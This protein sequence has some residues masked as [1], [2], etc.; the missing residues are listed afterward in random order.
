MSQNIAFLALVDHR[1]RSLVV[2]APGS[3]LPAL[4][5]CCHVAIN[6]LCAKHKLQKQHEYCSSTLATRIQRSAIHQNQ[7]PLRPK[8]RDCIQGG[9]DLV[10]CN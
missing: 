5:S 9:G 6:Y 8:Y 7:F 4:Q 3:V 2:A 10:I 1:T